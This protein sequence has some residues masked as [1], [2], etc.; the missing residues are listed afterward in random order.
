MSSFPQRPRPPPL[1]RPSQSRLGHRLAENVGSTTSVSIRT[2]GPGSSLVDQ[3]AQLALTLAIAK[4][5]QLLLLDEPV[6]S[7][8][9]L[10][11]RDS[12]RS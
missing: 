11:R 1:R 10:A 3:R 4:R 12:S 8:D 7:L 5:P 9:P 2:S 6:A